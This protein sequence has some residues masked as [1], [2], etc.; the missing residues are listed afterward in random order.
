M[1]LI[2]IIILNVIH[3]T[4]APHV[5][6]SRRHPLNSKKSVSLEELKPYPRL[7]FEQ[8][9]QN[10]FYFAEELCYTEGSPKNIIVTDRATLFNLL[11][12]L[13]GYTISSGI[14]SRDLNGSDII[15]IPLESSE[16]M[17][18]GFICKADD[19]IDNVSTSYVRYLKSA[20]DKYQKNSRLLMSAGPGVHSALR[21]LQSAC[22]F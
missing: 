13:N 10:S 19:P 18:I 11:I 17:E 21:S 22:L 1:Y 2:V 14:L 5:F 15:S 7:T 9:I 20:I 6:V 3:I 8:G 16:K 4:A 12:G